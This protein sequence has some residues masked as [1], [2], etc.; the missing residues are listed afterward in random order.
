MRCGGE[1]I[2]RGA[3]GHS[4]EGA[5][6]RTVTGG[7]DQRIKCVECGEEFLFTAGEQA[8]YQEHNLTHAPTRCKR[9]RTNRK[10]AGGAQGASSPRPAE[11][12]GGRELHAAVCS[13]CGNETMVPFVPSA[14]RPVYCRN[15]YASHR[16]ARSEA[17]PAHAPRPARSE[18]ADG[19]SRG[20]V[21]GSVKW[22]NQAKGFGFIRD[23]S[24]QEVF[25]HFSA[26]Q[27]DGLRTLA[28]GERVE[29]DV[30][31]GPKGNQAANVTRIG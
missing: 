9:C 2:L 26:L 10:G 30:V 22:F 1:V 19:G 11:V 7:A 29:F 20:R 4:L 27:G 13:N 5:P 28:Q 24:G 8:F 15:C 31:P 6:P 12:A 17:R 21:Q 25:V 23:D 18:M 14:G 3:A 16:P